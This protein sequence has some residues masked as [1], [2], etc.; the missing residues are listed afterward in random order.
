MLCIAAWSFATA[1]AASSQTTRQIPLIE[2]L[3][4]TNA[5]ENP[6]G[7][8]ET[9]QRVEKI[10]K[11]AVYVVYT[12]PNTLRRRTIRYADLDS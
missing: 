8:Y 10:D 12:A 4:L 9:H 1:N 6:R 7:D 2:G 5:I 3:M 11:E